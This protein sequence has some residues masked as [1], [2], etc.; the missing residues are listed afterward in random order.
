MFPKFF[1]NFC[2]KVCVL[3]PKI[4]RGKFRKISRQTEAYSSS[5]YPV[6]FSLGV[7]G[8]AGEKFYRQRLRR[9]Q[10]GF[11]IRLLLPDSK[12]ERRSGYLP[13]SKDEGIR[14]LLFTP[15][16]EAD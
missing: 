4:F 8:S 14:Y 15:R 6:I 12:T 7:R 5:F 13:Y 11:T 9:V 2:R 16:G 1:Q 10:G 3:V